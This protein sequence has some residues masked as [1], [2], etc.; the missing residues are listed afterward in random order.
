MQTSFVVIGIGKSGTAA[1]NLLL[2]SG[3]SAASVHTFD[4]KNREADFT[5]WEQLNTL[6]VGTLVVSPGVPLASTQM[7][8]LKNKGWKLTSEINLACA[9]LTD[10][11]LV[12]ITG[13]VG[14]STVTSLLG[15]ALRADDPNAFVGGNL[16]IPF[17]EYALQ[18]LKEKK[19]AKYIAIELSSY[20]LEN[21]SDL[22]LDY[23]AITF[24]S[25]NHLERYPSAD[26]YYMT[27][28]EIGAKT[29][30]VC[31]LNESSKD[32]VQYRSRIPGKTEFV[33]YKA[34]NEKSFLEKSHLI[35]E[36]NLDN[37]TIALKLARHLQL[38][39]Q[40][41]ETLT[42]FKGLCHRLETVGIFNGSLFIND[43]KATAM[44]SV[45][46]AT[47]A[48]LTKTDKTKKLYLLLGGKDK[49]LPWHELNVLAQYS[50]IHF[51]FFGQCGEL[52]QLKSQLVGAL[53]TKLGDA[54][55]YIL[56]NIQPGDV[57]L[58]SPGGTSLDEFKNFEDRGNYFKD[59][60]KQSA[61]Q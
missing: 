27:K 18:L 57:V 58:L 31:I 41:L 1:K 5:Q 48:A 28:C 38:S 32:L 16:G 11:I 42:Q 26:A 60:V 19:K 55:K 33:S 30:N 29:K 53:Y 7:T 61:A 45:L 3:V 54:V 50:N 35:G 59:L 25:S 46:V 8:A 22:K 43:S 17:A 23:S 24:L 2:A 52:A 44:D 49:N 20:Q 37:L 21:C 4:E 14:K 36:H 40:A 39:A 10:E 47:Q 9:H 6:P 34:S 51:I 13:S 15:E 56:K 12:G